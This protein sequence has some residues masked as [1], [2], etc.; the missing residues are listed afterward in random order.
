[1]NLEFRGRKSQ[2]ISQRMMR[3]FGVL[4]VTAIPII[5]MQGYVFNLWSFDRTLKGMLLFVLVSALIL[6]STKRGR[7][8]SNVAAL[9]IG[10]LCVGLILVVLTHGWFVAIGFL[11]VG[12][13][14]IVM[15]SIDRTNWFYQR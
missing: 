6:V 14:L 9:T 13:G 5:V 3:I 8:I 11:L 10:I 15:R 12:V 2:K 1:M 7:C 4:L